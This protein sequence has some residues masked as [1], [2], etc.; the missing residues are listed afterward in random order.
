MD[1]AAEPVLFDA[2][3]RPNP[4]MSANALKLVI[5]VVAAINLGFGLFFILRGAWPVT[6][7]MGADVLL[8]A[9]A[10]NAGRV[11]A[12]AYE[13]VRLTPESLIVLRQPPHGEANEVA[14][15]PYWVR[16]DMDD[17]PAR[18]SKLILWSHGRGIQIAKFLCPDERLSL[19]RALRAALS[20][21]RQ[22]GGG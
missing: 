15:N 22:S 17:P 3:L 21:S 20:R 9:W 7:F 1:A 10:L 11:A 13:R 4:P 14:L 6:P 8:L 12:R 19:A 16:V 18:T 2:T 5:G